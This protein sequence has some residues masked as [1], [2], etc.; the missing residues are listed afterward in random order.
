MVLDDIGQLR[1][2][3]HCLLVVTVLIKQIRQLELELAV[4]HNKYEQ[5]KEDWQGA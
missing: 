5:L 1:P 4:T 3:D 2:K